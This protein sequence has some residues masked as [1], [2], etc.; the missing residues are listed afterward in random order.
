MK[1][2]TKYIAFVAILHI[3]ALAMSWVIFNQNRIFFII[4]EAVIIISVIISWNLYRELLRP[5]RSMMQGIEAIRDQ[6]F[7]VKFVH[8]GKYEVDRLIGVYNDMIDHLRTERTKQEEQHFFLEKLVHTSPS[9]IIILDH[10][11]CIQQINPKAADMLQIDVRLL[12]RQ[13]VS[14]LPEVFAKTIGELKS[15]ESK[16]IKIKGATTCKINCSQFIDR[17]FARNFVVIEELTAELLAAEKNVYGKVIRMMAHEVNNTIGP[18]NSIINTALNTPILWQANDL[19]MLKDAMRIA[20]DRNQ[21][22][23]VFMRNFAD[24]V[25]LPPPNKKQ[26]DLCLTAQN[27][28]QLMQLPAEEK[29]VA[30][31]TD[32]P[33]QKMMV[34]ADEQQLEQV[35]INVIKNAIEATENN[36]KVHI[37]IDAQKRLLTITDDG[38]GISA[39]QS[40]HLFTPFYTTKSDGQ[41]IGLT[42]VREILTNHGFDFSLRTIVPNETVFKIDMTKKKR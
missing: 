14:S 37:T 8:T 32:L 31:S 25:K 34:M 38:K 20:A 18:V 15:G 30:I 5:L 27:V 2:R 39:E 21:N 11:N 35:L 28:V 1:L 16:T 3:A 4:A 17:G 10:D 23:N 42:L 7:N 12:M 22:L 9:G 6:D 41:G 19:N 24:L 36:G 29:K 33:R 13:P 26:I 40:A